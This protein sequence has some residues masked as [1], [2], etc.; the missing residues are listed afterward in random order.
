M[1][2]D[3]C[4]DSGFTLVETI[5]ATGLLAGALVSL[6]Q[7]LALSVASTRA[8][9]ATSSATILAQ[10]MTEQ[11]IAETTA[12]SIDYVDDAGNSLGGGVTPPPNAVYVRRAT[13]DPLPIHPN[14]VVIQVAVAGVTTGRVSNGGRPARPFDEVHLTTI[15]TRKAR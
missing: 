15:T 3:L 11:L 4:C 12:G 2:R 5:V 6:A 8:S 13:V 14:A 1:R 10:Q 9:R 7:M